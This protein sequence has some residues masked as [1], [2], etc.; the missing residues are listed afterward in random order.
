M[1]ERLDR[2]TKDLREIEGNA[3]REIEEFVNALK[4]ENKSEYNKLCDEVL[5][6]EGE[7]S[8]STSAES[9]FIVKEPRFATF[10]V[11][12]YRWMFGKLFIV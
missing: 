2:A 9:K 3:Q 1:Y 11:A 4:E 7:G 10:G 12:F 6:M 5:E 8:E